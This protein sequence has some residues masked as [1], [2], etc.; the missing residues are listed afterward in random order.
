M[1]EFKQA[2]L[3][4]ICLNL[5]T[6]LEQGSVSQGSLSGKSLTSTR[7]LEE[8]DSE[9]ISELDEVVQGNQLAYMPF[10]RSNRAQEQ[11]LDRH[12]EL[13]EELERSRKTRIDSMR[14][15]S[16]R[17]DDEQREANY[18]RFRVGSQEALNVTADLQRRRSGASKDQSP[19]QSPSIAAKDVGDDLPF[20]M[21]E[22]AAAR[23]PPRQSGLRSPSLLPDPT[24]DDE[25]ISSSLGQTPEVSRSFRS[26]Q[27]KEPMASPTS[28]TRSRPFFATPVASVSGFAP[29]QAPWQTS[30]RVSRGLGLKDIMEQ[31]SSGRMSNLTQSLKQAEASSKPTQ[32]VSQKERKR[33]AQ[34]Q[35]SQTVDDE[36]EHIS[37]ATTDT[38]ATPSTKQSPWQ[39]LKQVRT[40]SNVEAY[41]DKS[42]RESEAAGVQARPA[43]TTR[44]KVIR[45]TSSP[46]TPAPKTTRS[47]S[48]PAM[49]PSNKPTTPVIQSIRHTPAPARSG[50]SVDART[51][52]AEILAQQSFEKTAVKEAIA[53]RSLQEIQQ[54]QEFQEWWDIESQKVQEEEAQA[55]ASTSRRGKAGPWARPSEG[56]WKRRRS[57][58]TTKRRGRQSGRAARLFLRTDQR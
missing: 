52:M 13:T 49:T 42:R 20:E 35:K 18:Q 43:M 40:P 38:E 15:R 53:K 36:V 2:A 27:G 56:R 50:S 41:P 5:E 44:Q 51:S 58:C 23:R 22:D 9:L 33:Q 46:S 10:A 55:S 31:T 12:P 25:L 57:A 8:L 45:H 26:G 6:M 48:G 1:N 21:D 7:L 29:H 28:A 32:K 3:E 17:V 16:R 24:E 34:R 54:E 4:Y 30:P 19:G 37:M 11:L 47:V 39:D 14:L